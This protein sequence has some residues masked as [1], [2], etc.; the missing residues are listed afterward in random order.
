ME[1]FQDCPKLKTLIL[2]HNVIADIHPTAFQYANNIRDLDLS[3][4]S[5]ATL[6]RDLILPSV[7]SLL[8]DNN[9]LITDITG[10]FFGDNMGGQLKNLS[11]SNCQRLKYVR[12]G[13]FTGLPNL[14]NLYMHGNANLQLIERG[15]FNDTQTSIK[16]VS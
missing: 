5:L 4:N 3:Y 7:Q 14:R 9:N 10:E 6:P 15:A 11:I 8:L 13:A 1:T 12:K 16:V 2:S